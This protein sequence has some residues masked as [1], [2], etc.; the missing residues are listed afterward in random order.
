MDLDDAEDHEVLLTEL[1]AAAID[2]ASERAVARGADVVFVDNRAEVVEGPDL[3]ELLVQTQELAI[4]RTNT[5][6][7]QGDLT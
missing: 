6:T 3:G 2:V 4:A 1:K 7:A 5:R